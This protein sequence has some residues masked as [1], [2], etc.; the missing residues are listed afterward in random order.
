M[1]AERLAGG[2]VEAPGGAGA[3]AVSLVVPASKVSKAADAPLPPEA[4]PTAR[5]LTA[6]LERAA[7]RLGVTDE[8]ATKDMK[9]GVSSGGPLWATVSPTP[10]NARATGDRIYNSLNV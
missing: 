7:A 2:V 6:L 10:S 4:V 5:P 9:R 1:R 8:A 3:A